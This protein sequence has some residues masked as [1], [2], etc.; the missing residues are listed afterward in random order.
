MKPW[1]PPVCHRHH[2]LHGLR[3]HVQP[4]LLSHYKNWVFKTMW[5]G[6]RY[7]I[8][9]FRT[10]KYFLQHV[11][12]LWLHQGTILPI[13]AA[14]MAQ[15]VRESRGDWCFLEISLLCQNMNRNKCAHSHLVLIT[16]TQRSGISQEATHSATHMNWNHILAMSSHAIG[17]SPV[18]TNYL[19]PNKE[20]SVSV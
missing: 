7:T 4:T 1:S 14:S 2:I 5:F 10:D 12:W 18:S 15:W 3:Y 6:Q 11:M 16:Q 19:P 17:G 13:T 20:Y 9:N 8:Q